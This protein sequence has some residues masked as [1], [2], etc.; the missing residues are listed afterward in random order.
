M[1]CYPTNAPFPD[2]S[3][4]HSFTASFVSELLACRCGGVKQQGMVCGRWRAMGRNSVGWMKKGG[5]GR[6]QG[7]LLGLPRIGRL[8]RRAPRGCSRSVR[9]IDFCGGSIP[10]AWNVDALGQKAT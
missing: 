10:L 8:A 6:Q 2:R 9:G 4:A 5:H 1:H 7:M 3:H